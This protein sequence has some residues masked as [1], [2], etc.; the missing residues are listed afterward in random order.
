MQNSSITKTNKMEATYY[1]SEQNTYLLLSREEIEGIEV[2]GGIWMVRQFLASFIFV[3]YRYKVNSSILSFQYRINMFQITRDPRYKEFEN[4]NTKMDDEIIAVNLNCIN[5]EDPTNVQC[6]GGWFFRNPNPDFKEF[7]KYPS[8][9]F[10]CIGN[11]I[12]VNISDVFF[13]KS[14]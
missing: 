11:N 5:Y 9:K 13:S 2:E 8:L 6:N 12:L 7:L 4:S 10:N 1:N 14:F 3:Y